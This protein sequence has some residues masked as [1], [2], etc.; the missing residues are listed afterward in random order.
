MFRNRFNKE[1]FDKEKPELS[2]IINNNHESTGSTVKLRVNIKKV[3]IID[4][5]PI[6]L[7]AIIY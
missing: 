5:Y 7:I 3:K 6:N 2:Q 1:H 4:V